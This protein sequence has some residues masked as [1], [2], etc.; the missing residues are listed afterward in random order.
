MMEIYYSNELY[1]DHPSTPLDTPKIVEIVT[2]LEG[3]GC[4]GGTNNV[5]YPLASQSPFTFSKVYSPQLESSS[6]NLDN[7]NSPE[8]MPVSPN[9]VCPHTDYYQSFDAS[10][11]IVPESNIVSDFSE[12]LLQFEDFSPYSNDYQLFSGLNVNN[13]QCANTTTTT[14]TSNYYQQSLPQSPASISSNY[15]LDST[16]ATIQKTFT[17]LDNVNITTMNGSFVKQQDDSLYTTSTSTQ[18]PTVVDD[19]STSYNS[20]SSTSSTTFN[21]NMLK[22]EPVAQYD[23]TLFSKY[24]LAPTASTTTA[25]TAT[26]SNKKPSIMSVNIGHAVNISNGNKKPRMTKRE[27]QKQM[28]HNIERLLKENKDLNMQVELFEKQIRFCRNYLSE[29]VAPVLQ[30][31]QQDV[32]HA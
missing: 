29:H 4:L 14:N 7:L 26:R 18:V 8:M 1:E 27:K 3:Y 2:D 19:M 30:R 32:L 31:H 22:M 16:N 10:T 9:K 6:I 21:Q 13:N 5:N 24:Q 25:T 15:S 11:V 23:N 12:Q 28:E 20:N 17:C